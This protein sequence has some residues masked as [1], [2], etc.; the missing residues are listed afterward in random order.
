MSDMDGRR[1]AQVD[2][3]TDGQN[4]SLRLD[5]II[6]TG[7]AGAYQLIEKIVSSLPASLPASVFVLIHMG[8]SG[9]PYLD[10]LLQSKSRLSVKPAADGEKIEKGTIYTALPDQHLMLGRS[11]M[12]LRR[13]PRENGFRP[14]IDPLLRSAAVHFGTRAA[15]FVLSGLLDDGAAGLRALSSTGGMCFVQ[16]PADALYPDLPLSA[17]RAV[18]EATI[19]S[20]DDIP[21]VMETIAGGQVAAPRPTTDEIALELM[22][23]GMH[24]N[25][26]ENAEHLGRL[27]PFNCPECDGVLWE[28]ADGPIRRWRCHT[29][30][31]FSEKTLSRAQEY[32]LERTLMSTLRAHRG[33]IRAIESALEHSTPGYENRSDLQQKLS[34]YREDASKIEIMLTRADTEPAILPG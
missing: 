20:A 19:I 16:D 9:Y 29:G 12:H 27:A 6:L 22:I 2:G 31:A 18:P 26:I 32:Y 24:G 30:H 10:R 11:H 5:T 28:L 14:A 34:S 8:I 17:L 7:S 25:T 3:E 4:D 13:G 15:G 23:A 1:C 21:S 33:R